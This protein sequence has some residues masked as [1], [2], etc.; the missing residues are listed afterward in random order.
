MLHLLL[1]DAF[2][3]LQGPGDEGLMHKAGLGKGLLIDG[4][5]QSIC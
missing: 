2:Q 1:C 3:E 4:Y 5:T